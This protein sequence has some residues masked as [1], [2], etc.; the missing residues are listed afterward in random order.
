MRQWLDSFMLVLSPLR[1]HQWFWHF[2]EVEWSRNNPSCQSFH[3]S[4]VS[5]TCKTVIFPNIS[6]RMSM[7]NSRRIWFDGRTI[8]SQFVHNHTHNHMVVLQRKKLC[9]SVW[10]S[11]LIILKVDFHS[12]STCFYP[13]SHGLWQHSGVLPQGQEG[14]LSSPIQSPGRNKTKRKKEEAWKSECM[15]AWLCYDMTGNS[16]SWNALYH[17]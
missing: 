10:L 9:W 12:R 13:F 3:K 7:E 11:I 15:A 16:D 4:P 17:I 5:H 8:W 2:D 6:A 1:D 14:F